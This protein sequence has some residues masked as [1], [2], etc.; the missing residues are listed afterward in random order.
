MG[1]VNKLLT[2][3]DQNSRFVYLIQGIA[4]GI[5][6]VVLSAAFVM[7]PDPAAREGYVL[8]LGTLLGG[9]S[10]SSAVKGINKKMAGKGEADASPTEKVT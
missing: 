7:H 3:N 2:I 6:I 4:V 5:S 8:Y 1:F 10:L 9:G